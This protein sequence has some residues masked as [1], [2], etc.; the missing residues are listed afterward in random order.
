MC[1]LLEAN[2]PHLY[3]Y[4]QYLIYL[5]IVCFKHKCY[6]PDLL[7]HLS[8]GCCKHLCIIIPGLNP[9]KRSVTKLW[10]HYENTMWLACQ[11]FSVYACS[12]FWQGTWDMRVICLGKNNQEANRATIPPLVDDLSSH[13]LQLAPQLS[14]QAIKAGLWYELAQ[15]RK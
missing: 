10:K 4:I 2:R 1:E 15:S 7:P 8:G 9:W 12:K 5:K 13:L 14:L 3:W 11:I 6:F